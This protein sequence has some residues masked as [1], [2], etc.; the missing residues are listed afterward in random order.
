MNT[1]SKGDILVIDDKPANLQLLY[2]ILTE[3]GYQ[4]RPASSGQLGLDSVASRRPDLIL[5]DIRMPAMDG[6]DVCQQ[7]KAD[8]TNRDIPIIFVSAASDAVDKTKGFQLGAVDYI[9]KPFDATEILA[10]VKTHISL[11]RYQ[12]ELEET[13]KSLEQTVRKRTRELMNTNEAL[14][15]SEQYLR[16]VY[17]AADN[18]ALIATDLAGSQTI[19]TEFSPG[20][21]TIFG[22]SRN[23]AIN[24]W[25][26][27][28]VSADWF[29]T[30]DEIQE[31]LRRCEPGFSGEIQLKRKGGESFSALLA[32]HP[33]LDAAKRTIGMVVVAVDI[34]ERKLAEETLRKNEKLLRIIAENYPNSYL[35]II[36]EDFTIGFTS[37]QEFK[38][39]DLEPEQFVGLTLEQVFGAD[40]P[41]VLEYYERTFNGEECSF[42]LYMNHQYQLYRTVP[43]PADDGSIRRILAVAENITERKREEQ[44]QA[45]Q[46]R[47]IE[48]SVEHSVMELLQKFLDEAEVLTNSEIGFYHFLEEDQETLSLQNWS[49][50]TLQNMCAAEGE[51]MH[52]PI[53]KAGVWVDCVRQRRPVIHNDYA[54]LAFRKGLP[55]GHA[56]ILRELVAPVF[57]GEEIVAILGV[58]NKGADYTA[59]DLRIVKQLADQAW[60]TVVRK[61][62]ETALRES[63]ELYRATLSN[64]SDAVFITDDAGCFT[65]VCPNVN[66][67]FG[68]H[69]DEV[70]QLGTIS[71]LL[72]EGLFDLPTLSEQGEIANIPRTISDKEG[73]SHEV[74]INVKRVSIKGGTI[75]YSC[76]DVTDR[77][78]LEEMMVQAEKMATVGGLAAGMAHEINN[79]LG[80]IL[81]GAQTIERRLSADLPANHEAAQHHQ[82]DLAAIRAY[83]E[84]RQVLKMIA[85]IKEA[86]SRAAGIVKNMLQFSRRSDVS[87]KSVVLAKLI[88]HAI[89]LAGSDYDL[90][91]QYDFHNIQL[92]C[93]Y[94]PTLPEI[95]CAPTEIEQV[96]LN[97]FKN[98][99][100][101][102]DAVEDLTKPRIVIRTGCADDMAWIEVEDN[103]PGMS[104]EIRRRIFEPFFTTKEVGIG[105]GLGLSV[106]YMIIA[107]KHKGTITVDSSPGKGTRF[108][109]NLPIEGG[110]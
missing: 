83:L 1:E 24:Q 18:V 13:K 46:L 62:A 101:A 23:E 108:T 44:L 38:K 79:P 15:S 95:V 90:K 61:Q 60:E 5:L 33:Q 57:R 37:G 50:N 80:V 72:G 31:R 8:E 59:T 109:I 58:G 21:E 55:E 7:L 71:C 41:T 48:Y 32:I 103:G 36:E 42:E 34:T 76:R 67:I 82:V 45:A 70:I 69:R 65:Y 64:I 73:K 84:D 92:E 106:S 107:D 81:Q 52:H 97:L 43:L 89:E 28:L 100:Q 66:T 88:D 49:T 19:I 74:L 86:G 102:L 12:R 54:S 110:N 20:A 17:E 105:T 87:K 51:A 30:I 11:Y 47:L 75:L 10:R 39:R 91:K 6:F 25:L 77:V 104:E 68:H 56:P 14:S 35:S 40:T 99:A 22:Y 94:D 63:E 93:E 26:A 53:S 78:R 4:V 29:E 85:L 3:V 2:G 98:A 27:M 9:T 96:L 16:S